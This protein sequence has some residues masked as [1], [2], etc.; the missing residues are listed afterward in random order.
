VN[1]IEH[2][3]N[4]SMDRDASGMI[5]QER[6]SVL[7]GRSIAPAYVLDNSRLSDLDPHDK[8]SPCILGAPHNGF[9]RLR[10]RTNARLMF[11]FS[12]SGQPPIGCAVLA[13]S[14]FFS[15]GQISSSVWPPLGWVH[16]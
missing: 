2:T 5:A 11:G 14:Q 12:F 10:R 8:S 3:T 7:R 16:K 6:L 15:V 9:S 1:E 4:K 13:Q